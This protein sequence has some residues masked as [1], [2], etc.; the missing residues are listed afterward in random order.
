MKETRNAYRIL[1]GKP[2]GKCPLGRTKRWEDNMKMDL[3]DTGCEDQR[4]MK[5]AQDDTLLLVVKRLWIVLLQ[6]F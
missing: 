1:V 6:C 2:S 4:W 3:R 5:L